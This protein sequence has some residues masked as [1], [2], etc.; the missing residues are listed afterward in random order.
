MISKFLQILGLQPGISKLF[1]DHQNI[2]FSQKVRTILVAKYHY[3]PLGKAGM[4]KRSI[5]DND[6]KQAKIASLSPVLKLQLALSTTIWPFSVWIASV[7]GR[8]ASPP[9]KAPL[10]AIALKKRQSYIYFQHINENIYLKF[11]KTGCLN[12][13]QKNI[14][15]LYWW[16]IQK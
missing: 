1:L 7:S 5:A 10:W 12:K 14:H 8:R 2:F 11:I 15:G 13:R 9:T 6:C 16:N 3:L 4:A